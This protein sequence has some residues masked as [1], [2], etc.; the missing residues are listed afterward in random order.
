[1]SL[2]AAERFFAFL[3]LIAAA[4]AGAIVIA[5]LFPAGRRV[6]GELHIASLWLAWVVAVTC[7]VGSLYFSDSLGLLPCKLCWYQ[8][9]AMY[10][11]AVILLVAAIRRDRGVRWYAVPLA[12]IGIVISVYHYLIEWHP[13]W[14]STSCDITVPCTT[15]YFRTFGF[16]SISLMA[17]CGFAAILALLLLV[18]EP[19]LDESTDD[20]SDDPLGNPVD[21]G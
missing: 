2:I 1:V 10:P 5:R 20:P 19:V 17:M 8:R 13:E 18:P 14:E 6:S 4:G 11:L 12:G 15:P 21:Q 16:V 7:M 3:A 9:V